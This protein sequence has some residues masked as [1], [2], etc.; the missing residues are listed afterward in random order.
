MYR[1]VFTGNPL[2][3]GWIQDLVDALLDALLD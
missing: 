1:T 2:D 3:S